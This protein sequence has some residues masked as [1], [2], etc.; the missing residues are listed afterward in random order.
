MSMAF[1][2]QWPT[3][4]PRTTRRQKGAFQMTPG[5]ARDELLHQLRLLGA[6]DVVISSN[7]VLTKAGLP[8]AR[9]GFVE[10]PGVAVY[11]TLRGR[12]L[13]IPCDKWTTIDH[14]IRAIGLTVEALRG[15]ERWGAKQ[16]V[17]AAFQ[18]F[19]ALPAGGH[20]GWWTVLGVAPDADRPT[21]EAAWRRLVRQ[22]HPDAGGDLERFRVVQAAY[23]QAMA[24][25]RLSA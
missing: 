16:M 9:Q 4:W 19:A 2:L 21:I 7:A 1:P 17:D 25:A 8:A 3:G 13:A 12:A 15:L 14:N 24:T 10:D 5:R 23:D 11:F 22:H 20:G 6:R 18:G